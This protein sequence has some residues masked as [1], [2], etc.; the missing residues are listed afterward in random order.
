[1]QPAASVSAMASSVSGA[2][3]TFNVMQPTLSASN[4]AILTVF[5]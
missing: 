5:S 1:L 4:G 2:S 3:S